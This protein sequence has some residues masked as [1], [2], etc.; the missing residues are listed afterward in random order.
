MLKVAKI[1]KTKVLLHQKV[2]WN[3]DYS[4]ILHFLLCNHVIMCTLSRTWKMQQPH[5]LGWLG[6]KK[7]TSFCHCCMKAKSPS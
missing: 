3:L 6:N 4:V 2:V 1:P 5:D 7:R